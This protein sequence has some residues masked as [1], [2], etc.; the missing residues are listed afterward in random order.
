MLSHASAVPTSV[1]AIL[2][3]GGGS[4]PVRPNTPVLPF[5][6]PY[7]TA[8]FLD[9]TDR[10]VAGTRIRIGTKDFLAP[11]VKLDAARGFIKIGSNTTIQDHATLVANPD[12]SAGVTGITVGDNVAIADGAT[13]F[14]PATIGATGG[15]ATS[16]GA[17]AVIDGATIAPGAFVGALARVGPG[18][19]VPTGFRV[20]P[21]ANVTTDAQASDPVFGKVIRV[22]TADTTALAKTLTDNAG[23]ASGYSSLYQGNSATGTASSSTPSGIF[24]G[25][26]APVEG[27]GNEPGTRLVSF[28]P[29]QQAPR[30]LFRNGKSR[31][32]A[33]Y[34][35]QARATGQV[36]F[37]QKQ[38]VAARAIGHGVSIRGDE[39]QPITIA[40]L[41]R[42]GNNVSIHSPNG[43]ITA[44]NSTPTGRITIGKSFRARANAV[45]LGGPIAVTIGDNVTVGSNAVV[46]DSSIGAGATIGNG[47]YV[48]NSTIAAGTVVADGAIIINNVRVGTVGS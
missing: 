39:G 18:V 3:Q 2:N 36:I 9:P 11:F 24:N 44:T 15:A 19:T 7:A 23:L 22:T 4:A 48:A 26:L 1:L 16:I 32:S 10:I 28:E 30:F 29:V 21:G 8:S 47:A 45:I 25:S 5:E 42:L 37:G 13:I 27:S 46:A 20:L 17:N 31:Q 40:S 12:R 35:F 33:D 6:S 43:G 14:G 38:A 41:A 34:R